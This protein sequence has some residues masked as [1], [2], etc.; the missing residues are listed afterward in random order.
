MDK[1][2]IQKIN[3]D[4]LIENVDTRLLNG[5]IEITLLNRIYKNN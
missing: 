1:I 3:A 4:S 2:E 5:S